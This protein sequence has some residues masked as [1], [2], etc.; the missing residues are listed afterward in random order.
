[1]E[2]EIETSS[3]GNIVEAHGRRGIG[4]RR[5]LGRRI[6]LGGQWGRGQHE[7]EESK[8][9]RGRGDFGVWQL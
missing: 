7:T 8:G 5:F 1:M 2:D 9:N 6:G 3:G 4:P